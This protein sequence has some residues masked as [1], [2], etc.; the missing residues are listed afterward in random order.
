MLVDDDVEVFFAFTNR[1]SP[2]FQVAQVVEDSYRLP[3][4]SDSSVLP[5]TTGEADVR[6]VTPR[7]TAVKT[8]EGLSSTSS[9]GRDTR[10]SSL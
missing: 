1:W 8:P 6:L 10:N 3:R 7:P 2:G 9:T 4:A 5:T